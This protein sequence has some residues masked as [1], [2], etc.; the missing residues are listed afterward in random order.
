MNNIGIG[1]MCFGDDYYFQQIESKLNEFKDKKVECYILTDKPNNFFRFT[2][3]SNINIIPYKRFLKSYHD[4]VIL[5]KQILRYHNVAILIDTDTF[6]LDYS[7]IDDLINYPYKKGISY[8]ESLLTHKIKKEFI[9]DIQ[10]NPEDIDWFN[11]RMYVQKIFPQ[12]GDLE[13]IYE[14]FLVFNIDGLKDNF[15]QNYEK[16]QVIKE[17][18]DV[19]SGRKTIVGSA[20]GV[21]IHVSARITDTQIQRDNDLYVLIKDK[22]KNI[23]RK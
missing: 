19:I 5:V 22:I 2:G 13:T 10:M 15:F 12:Y 8:V 20:E 7:F 21:S 4:K 14:Y 9:K 6:I 3:Y 18:C 17:S 1:I 16:L 11:Y 23:N